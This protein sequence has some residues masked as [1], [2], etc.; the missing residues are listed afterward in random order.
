MDNG[1]CPELVNIFESA[2]RR[3]DAIRAVRAHMHTCSS[4]EP[5]A[6]VSFI[7]GVVLSPRTHRTSPLAQVFIT[8]HIAVLL[9]P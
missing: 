8:N 7:T 4:C 1:T 9:A 5:V 3:R 2:N 6:V